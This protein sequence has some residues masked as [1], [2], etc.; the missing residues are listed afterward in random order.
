[1]D[2]NADVRKYI[3]N[4]LG[5]EYHILEAEDGEKG[6]EISC[7]KFPDLI[8]SDVMMP[9]MDGIEL[10]RRI[11]MDQVISHLPVIL[12]TARAG[13]ED[14]LEGLGTGA[15]DYITKPFDAAELRLRITNILQ[16]RKR[17]RKR[18]CQDLY[19]KPKEITVTSHDERFISDLITFIDKHIS[20][21][22]LDVSK[23]CRESGLSHT[24]L[25]RKLMALVDLSVVEFIRLMRLRRA[26]DLLEKKFGNI[27]EV[28]FEVGF[29]SVA[30]FSH[31][32][33]RQFG[34]NP[35]E[36]VNGNNRRK[37]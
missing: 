15:D 12:I 5:A 20:D 14:K 25:N 32:Y 29:N 11:K 10:C 21:P 2:D 19:V 28:A 34:L 18:F 23:I 35:S 13:A 26:K 27:S 30:Y 4:I 7:K 8:I 33:R 17:L 16:Q 37:H 24:H 6:I 3:G 22:D 36:V 31:C 1:M 9:G